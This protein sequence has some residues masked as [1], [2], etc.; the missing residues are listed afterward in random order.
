V[1]RAGEAV[2]WRGEDRPKKKGRDEKVGED[3][4]S[5]VAGEEGVTL[6]RGSYQ[7]P[8]GSR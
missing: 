6:D 3:E 2:G 7:M 5:G 1:G 8:F 4:T